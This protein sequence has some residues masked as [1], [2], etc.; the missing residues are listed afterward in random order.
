MLRARRPD[1]IAGTRLI[2]RNSSIEVRQVGG[3]KQ[4]HKR[5]HGEFS[6]A[7]ELASYAQL[8]TVV[9]NLAGVRIARLLPSPQPDEEIVIEFLGGPTM[10]QLIERA[11]WPLVTQ[12]EPRVVALLV[13]S[14][15][16]GCFFDFDPANFIWQSPDLV[17]ID[18][19]SAA[20]PLTH[21]NAAVYLQ[22]LAK[23]ALRT[24]VRPWRLPALRRHG[25][26]ISAAYAAA[27]GVSQ[28]A[29]REDLARY[30]DQVIAWN[31]QPAA[32]E[33]PGYRLLRG[34]ALVPYYRLVRALA[35][36]A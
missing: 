33:S 29:V 28:L 36:R 3:Q 12:L 17:V 24:V 5:Y 4:V 6:A 27:C 30:L 14:W 13:A 1:E 20:T 19:T 21:L 9:N 22:G 2:R 7:D 16:S 23:M 25:L 10:A 32:S 18:P 35:A 34:I 31:R 26:R 8:A 11:E 15:R